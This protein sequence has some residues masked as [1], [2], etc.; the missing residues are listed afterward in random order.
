M[1]KQISRHPGD[2]FWKGELRIAETS[3]LTEWLQSSVEKSLCNFC[4]KVVFH[5]AAGEQPVKPFLS[6]AVELQ[7][8]VILTVIPTLGHIGRGIWKWHMA[9]GIRVPVGGENSWVVCL[10]NWWMGSSLHSTCKHQ[11]KR[12]NPQTTNWAEA[13][14]D[15]CWM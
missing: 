11:T 15:K 3:G 9:G 6:E 7:L 10:G 13:V 14:S 2:C 8:E 4:A 1:L 12:Q 5:V